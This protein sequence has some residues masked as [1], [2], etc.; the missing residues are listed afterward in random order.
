MIAFLLYGPALDGRDA[1]QEEKYQRLAEYFAS[2][3]TQVVT[4]CYSEANQAEVMARVRQVD[5]TLVWINPIE[6]GLDRSK[7][8]AMLS[9][10]IAEGCPLSA[11]PATILKLGTKNILFDTRDWAWG[12]DVRRYETLADFSAQFER[13]LVETGPRVLKQYRGDGGKGVFQV[14]GLG[15]RFFQVT[16][17]SEG[18]VS[19][20][21]WDELIALVE[22][23]FRPGQ[24]LIDQVWSADLENGVVRCYL[25]GARVVGF[26]YQ[27][28]NMLYPRPLPASARRRHYYT[29]ACGL[30]QDL[31]VLVENDIVPKLLD[32]YSLKE[33]SLPV[34][35]DADC[36]IHGA[37]RYS[38]CE[39]NASCISPFPESAIAYVYEEVQGRLG[40]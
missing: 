30:F 40:R 39:V 22:P 20:L 31:R 17:A 25:T 10:L 6:A 2:H 3:G 1:F 4:L 7:L 29:E 32:Q 11:D 23:Y 35:W 18:T 38:L 24:P 9:T 33:E 28:I 19:R 8:D 26:G 15:G 34:L 14:E 37:G 5:F 13:T 27:E 21:S 12:S 36:F 16:S